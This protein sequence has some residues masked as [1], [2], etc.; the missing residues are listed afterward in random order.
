MGRS[1]KKYKTSKEEK[2]SKK[3]HEGVVG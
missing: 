3:N 1:W 2:I